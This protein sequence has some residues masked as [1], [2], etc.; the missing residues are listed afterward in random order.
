MMQKVWQNQER[1]VEV[2]NSTYYCE[3]R[4]AKM[5]GEDAE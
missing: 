1:E 4:D 5:Q 2:D 3:S